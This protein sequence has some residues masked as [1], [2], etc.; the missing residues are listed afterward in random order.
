C[1]STNG[2]ATAQDSYN[3]AAV[4]QGD[5]AA[6]QSPDIVGNLRV[7]QAW[8][9]AQ[10]GGAL[11]QIRGANYGSQTTFV[12]VSTGTPPS[13]EWGFAANAGIILN[14]PWNAGDK[15]WVEGTYTEGAIG[16]LSFSAT[17]G[18]SFNTLTRFNGANVAVAWA[19]DGVFANNAVLGATGI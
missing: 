6:N 2:T 16:Y 17:N 10:V 1:T 8:G 12:G 4:N 19:L 3:V 9:S 14:V 7:D 13:D 11:H 18:A 15:F 5:Y